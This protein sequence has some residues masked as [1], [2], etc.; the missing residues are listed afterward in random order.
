MKISF[1]TEFIRRSI[2]TAFLSLIMAIGITAVTQKVQAQVVY[3]IA[4][5]SQIKVSGTSNLHD[6]SMLAN[7]F[8]CDGAFVV[9]NGEIQDIKSLNFALPVT[10][11]KSKEDLMDSR[12]Y[13][14]LKAEEFSKITFRLT[15]ATIM[16]Q[17]KIKAN[18]NLTIGGVTSQVTL[19]TSYVVNTDESIVFKGTKA[20][21]MS[22]HKIKAPS[23]MMGALKTGDEVIVDLLLK[24]KK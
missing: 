6:W 4:A 2:S 14:T 24:L 23:F 19:L 12:A 9:Q 8:S 3:K 11:L 1:S 5:G 20:I 18:G 15:D 10:N 16:P 13:K 7:S 17:Q 21:K 22:D